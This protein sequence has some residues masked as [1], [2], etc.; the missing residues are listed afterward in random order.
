MSFEQF[1]AVMRRERPA[2]RSDL[3]KAFRKL[4]VNGDGFITADELKRLLTKV[5]C[6]CTVYTCTCT[7]MVH[8]TSNC[9]Y[10]Y[11]CENYFAFFFANL[12]NIIILAKMSIP[13]TRYWEKLAG[14]KFSNFGQSAMFFCLAGFF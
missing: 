5:S 8:C 3:M 14:I 6:S 4:D 1:C 13:Y 10:M 12:D 9:L 11:T 7:C 2:S